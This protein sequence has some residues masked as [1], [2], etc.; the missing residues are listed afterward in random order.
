MLWSLG[1]ELT[2][3][4]TTTSLAMAQTYM[5]DDPHWLCVEGRSE[6]P[7]RR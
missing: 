2:S 1:V 5:A 6:L 3:C 4:G 7:D